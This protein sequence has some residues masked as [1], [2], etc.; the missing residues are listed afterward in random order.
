[1]AKVAASKQ[2]TR[3]ISR[4][5]QIDMVWEG[6][7]VG[8][9]SGAIVTAYRLSL[10]KSEGFLRWVLVKAHLSLPG[11]VGF[12]VLLATSCLVV[13]KLV[14][15]EPYTQGSG[16]PQVDAEVMGRIDMP[17]LRV[18]VA[19]FTE[20]SLLTLSGLSLGREGP[21]I[22]LGGM[23]GKAVSRLLRRGR[24]EERLLIT[25][26]AA[27]GMSTAFGAPLTGTLF[28][29]EEIHKEFTPSLIVSAMAAAVTSDF[30][31]SQVLGVEPVLR[32]NFLKELP[33]HYYIFVVLFGLLCGVLGALHNRGMF[34]CSERVFGRMA[35]LPFLARLA[36]PFALTAVAAFAWPRLLCGG[37]A[38]VELLKE[39]TRI[40]VLTLAAL[41]VGKYLFTTVCFSSGAPGGTL[42]PLCVMGMLLGALYGSVLASTTDLLQVYMINFMALG[43]AGIFSAVVRAPITGVVLAFELTGSMSAL[44]SVSIVAIIAYVVAN[45]MDVD[46]F[47]EH[48]LAK[49]L[50]VRNI[51]SQTRGNVMGEKSLHA[52]TVGAGSRVDGRALKD[53]AWPESSRIITIDRA[54]VDVLPTGATRLQALDEILVIMNAAEEDEVQPQIWDLC[55]SS[56]AASH[57]PRQ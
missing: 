41:L 17:W 54:G 40:P 44:L 36:L 50:G 22:Q 14:N 53:I 18:L 51:R 20:G 3:R 10:T 46:P 26:G 27:A 37:D 43:I 56:L 47:Y 29:I 19:K 33:H 1:M 55:R 15:W 12:L 28:A 11:L 23:G 2:V 39:P 35:G 5:F 57:A 13:A 6:A 48:L 24:G 52:Y 45:L 21:S 31:A 30:L 4:R 32:L 7:L 38:I 49:L 42:F 8:L 34:A 25:C 9:V 16:I